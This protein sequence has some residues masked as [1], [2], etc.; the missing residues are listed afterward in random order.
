MVF[1]ILLIAVFSVCI[2]KASSSSDP[3]SQPLQT[4]QPDRFVS[5]SPLALAAVCRDGVAI[6]ATHTAAAQEPL[7]LEESHDR[8][9]V[10]ETETCQSELDAEDNKSNAPAQQSSAS[11]RGMDDMCRSPLLQ[12]IPLGHRGPFRIDSIDGS[13]TTLVCAGWRTDCAALAARCRS[14]AASEIARYGAT[15]VGKGIDYGR[16]LAKSVASWMAQCSFSDNVRPLSCVGLLASCGKGGRGCLWLV[17]ATGAHRARAHAVGIGANE[18]NKQLVRIDF[19]T[20]SRDEGAQKLLEA[21]RE[22][23][24]GKND[25][26]CSLP[27]ST[28]V[29]IAVVDSSNKVMKRRR[30]PFVTPKDKVE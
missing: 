21:V 14:V 6:L 5:A 10:T 24:F 26:G 19:S 13:G 22:A 27:E 9:S 15:D 23:G 16:H 1:F 8:A 28:T 18:V 12:D 3:H 17:D 20:V 30:Q 29:E 11:A 2:L 7:L 4:S 25:K